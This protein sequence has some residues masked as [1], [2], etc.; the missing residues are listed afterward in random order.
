MW[1]SRIRIIGS[2]RGSTSVPAIANWANAVWAT[3]ALST[4]TLLDF[5][6]KLHTALIFALKFFSEETQ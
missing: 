3:D 4:L 5:D 2:H 1:T 6:G